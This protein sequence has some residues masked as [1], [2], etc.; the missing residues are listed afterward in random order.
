MKD[1]MTLDKTVEGEITTD[2][3]IEIDRITEEM[4]PDKDTEIGVKVGIGQ[5]ITVMTALEVETETEMDRCNKDPEL[6]QM[7]EKDLGPG[8]IQE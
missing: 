6:W 8:L 7:T 1:E 3:I 2:K 4:T 5:E